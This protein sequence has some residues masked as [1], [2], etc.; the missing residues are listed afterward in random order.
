MKFGIER[1]HH[2][3]EKIM[4]FLNICGL[5]A[6][7]DFAATLDI[8]RCKNPRQIQLTGRKRDE[9]AEHIPA[10][11]ITRGIVK[12][13]DKLLTCCIHVHQSDNRLLFGN[14]NNWNNVVRLTRLVEK[15]C[16]T[17]L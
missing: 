10:A 3:D 7:A 4:H 2:Q 14:R 13:A 11:H 8:L 1:A 5:V 17:Q 15:F 6:L 9:I 16:K 12:Q